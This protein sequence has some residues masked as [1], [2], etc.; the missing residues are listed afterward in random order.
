M[1]R[2]NM[3]TTIE[4]LE[5]KVWPAPEYQSSLVLTAHA[6]RK[7]PIEELTP[8]E[9]R[10]AFNEDIGAEFLKKRVLEV[11][12]EEPAVGDLFAGDL[13]LA[14]MRSE[15]FRSD[16]GFRKKIIEKAEKALREDLDSQTRD[17]IEML[18]KR[19]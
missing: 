6:L 16:S 10:V 9:L 5:G 13:I 12:K 4:A 8:N 18:R 15:Q 19:G 2:K 17:E 14:V 11:L 1:Q 3:K 7:K